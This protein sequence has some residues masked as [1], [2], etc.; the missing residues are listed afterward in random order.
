[1]RPVQ[2]VD[3]GGELKQRIDGNLGEYHQLGPAAPSDIDDFISRF[4]NVAAKLGVTAD[5][6]HNPSPL[7][8]AGIVHFP[9]LIV[10][11]P[12]FSYSPDKIRGFIDAHISGCFGVLG[13]YRADLEVTDAIVWTLYAQDTATQNTVSIKRG[14]GPIRSKY[15]LDQA[16]E[17]RFPETLTPRRHC[18]DVLT[19]L[20]PKGTRTLVSVGDV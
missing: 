19:A 20:S 10:R 2:L 6:P 4:P 17:M 7:F 1:M 18:I 3:L 14:S 16:D 11:R 5:P 8:D 15:L 9:R 13:R 12:P